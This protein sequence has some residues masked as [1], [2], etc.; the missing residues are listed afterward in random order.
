MPRSKGKASLFTVERDKKYIP[1]HHKCE[2]QHCARV[3]RRHIHNTPL[4]SRIK[5]RQRQHHL[6]RPH[7]RREVVLEAHARLVVL[8]G[9]VVLERQRVD[10]TVGGE[11][12]DEERVIAGDVD[13]CKRVDG[14]LGGEAGVRAW[15]GKEVQDAGEFGLVRVGENGEVRDGGA[16]ADAMRV[17]VLMR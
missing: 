2:P 8:G 9:H 13:W 16:I 12:L 6:A 11:G 4:V 5:V 14:S 10:L 3:Q 7:G 15:A 1:P 17:W